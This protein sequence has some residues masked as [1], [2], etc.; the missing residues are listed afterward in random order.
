MT[1]LFAIAA[2]IIFACVEAASADDVADFYAG[3]QITFIVG[4]TPGGGYDLYARILAEH[5]ARHIP[6]TPKV[7]VQNMAAASGVGAANHVYNIA[8]KDG[9]VIAMCSAG[10]VLTELLDPPR[11]KYRSRNFGWIGTA[12]TIT[13]VLAVFKSSGVATLDDARQKSVTIGAAGKNGTL[14]MQPALVNSLL[15]TKFQI[16]KG[17]TSGNEINLAMDRGE[18]QGRTNQLDS[19]KAQRPAWVREGKLNYL[20]QFGPKLPDLPGVP[21]FDELV[22]TPKDKAVVDLMEIIQFVG[23]SIYTPPG[24]PKER[25]AALRAA[26]DLTMTDPDYVAKTKQYDLDNYFRKGTELQAD[27]DRIMQNTDSI[28]RDFKQAVDRN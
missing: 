4:T 16:V 11:V 5:I 27:L 28:V 14:S 12:S 1:R 26:F 8:P 15:G 6:G 17:Y 13:D 23:R 24:I 9:T 7:V 22:T 25:L 3:R 19:W 20:L 10:I 21:S 2:V 18:V